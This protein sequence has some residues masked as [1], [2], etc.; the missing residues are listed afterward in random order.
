M[1][2]LLLICLFFPLISFGAPSLPNALLRYPDLKD[3]VETKNKR[4]K[5]KEGEQRAAKLR[6]GYL[7]RSFL[8]RVEAYGAQE[9][10]K[11]GRRDFVSQPAYGAEARFNLFNAGRD[12]L[13]DSLKRITTKRKTHERQITVIEELV[14]A[15][16]QYWQILY[17][18][19]TLNLLKEARALNDN[20]LRAAERRL[21]SGVATET[22]RVEFEMKSVD[23]KR[24]VEIAELQL[25]NLKTLLGTVLGLDEAAEIEATEKLDHEHDLEAAVSHES[26]DHE[27]LLIPKELAIQEL[28]IAAR[29][30]GRTYWPKLDAY[31]GWNQ[32][33]QRE[34]DLSFARDRT[35]AVIGLRVS[36]T[37]FDGLTA[38]R[39]SSALKAESQAAEFDLAFQREDMLAHIHN[40]LSELEL[41]HSQVHDAEVNIKRAFRYYSLTQSEYSRGVKN[42]PDV[43]GAAEKL[44]DMKQKHLAII[45]DFQIAK[46]HVLSK[47]G[48]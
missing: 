1:K 28:G 15:R 22:D 19:D 6:E 30:I 36:L 8:P 9:S 45:R 41:L 10:F 26:K 11:I 23:L 43:L 39:E 16:E 33:N 32:F 37:L 34:E 13:D 31:A 2:F 3:L 20:N 35:Q 48:R 14:R 42:S 24:E 18:R 29:S 7:T 25:Q 38:Y 27:F 47:L 17:L 4:V 12:N 5:A 44:F 21:K 40:E 46:A